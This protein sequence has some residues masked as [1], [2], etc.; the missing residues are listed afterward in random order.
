M[1]VSNSVESGRDGLTVSMASALVNSK[2]AMLHR[3]NAYAFLI[4]APLSKVS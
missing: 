1:M 4:C 3:T 2:H